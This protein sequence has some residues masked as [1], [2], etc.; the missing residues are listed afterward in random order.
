[1]IMLPMNEI[2]WSIKEMLNSTF[3]INDSTKSSTY[4]VLFNEYSNT[5]AAPFTSEKTQ[6]PISHKIGSFYSL[7]LQNFIVDKTTK[8]VKTLYDEYFFKYKNILLDVLPA[9]QQEEYMNLISSEN[10]NKNER[11]NQ[12]K[13][14]YR[15]Y[16]NLYT[17]FIPD[18]YIAEIKDKWLLNI[19]RLCL[20]AYNI[21]DQ[22]FIY[23]L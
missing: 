14:T 18:H 16:Q 13:E 1:M 3:K 6:I 15:R 22:V 4:P 21:N 20:R 2:D 19:V 11:V 7:S 5:R 9:T 23:L 8:S 12:R 10:I 17:N